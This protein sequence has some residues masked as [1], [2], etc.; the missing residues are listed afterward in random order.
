MKTALAHIM[1]FLIMNPCT[2]FLQDLL[3]EKYYF[4]LPPDI[5]GSLN[6]QQWV[7]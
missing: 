1:R 5:T 7:K 2:P 3:E 4:L 6:V